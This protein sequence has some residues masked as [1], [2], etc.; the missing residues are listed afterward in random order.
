MTKVVISTQQNVGQAKA[1]RKGK[2]FKESATSRL[3]PASYIEHGWAKAQEWNAVER[4]DHQPAPMLTREA[5]A[6]LRCPM[7]T[8]EGLKAMREADDVYHH[9]R[10]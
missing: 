4:P 2:A 9:S 5:V 10:T 1:N 6:V 7:I 3:K 8:P